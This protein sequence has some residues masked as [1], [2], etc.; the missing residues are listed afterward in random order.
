MDKIKS[1]WSNLQQ[2]RKFLALTSGGL[3]AIALGAD[4]FLGWRGLY[5][6]AMVAAAVVAGYDIAARA[7]ASLRN[8]HSSIELLV[9]VAALG[10]L[11]IGEYWEAAAVTF[12]FILG[13]Y[14]EARTLSHT[15]Q[16]LGKLL[17]LAPITANVVRNGL[18]VEVLAHEVEPG[19]LVLVKPGTKVPVDGEVVDG[20]SAVDESAITGEPMPEEKSSGSKVFAGTLNQYGLLHVRATGIGGDTTLARIIR[21]VEEAQDEKA[22]TQRFIERFARWYTPSIILLSVVVF[23]ISGNIELGLLCL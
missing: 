1:I 3:I 2:R 15:R 18:Q 11:W 16:V 17:D 7:I 6:I 8:R 5:D 14:L 4:Y 13:A 19:E 23:A 22:P 12:L 9:T 10:A 21:R 20:Q